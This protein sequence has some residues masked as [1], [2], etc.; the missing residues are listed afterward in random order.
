MGLQEGKDM[1]AEI[2]V[3]S[4]VIKEVRGGGD[5]IDGVKKKKVRNGSRDHE[6]LSK[7][8]TKRC[9]INARGN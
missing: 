7:S 3:S 5:K 2:G 9:E 6:G 8:Q 4:S 1:Q